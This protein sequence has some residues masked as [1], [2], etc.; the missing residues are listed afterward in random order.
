ACLGKSRHS[1]VSLIREEAPYSNLQGADKALNR[2]A[3]SEPSTT[4]EDVECTATTSNGTAA[5]VAGHIPQ[6]HASATYGSS[7]WKQTTVQ[8]SGK[9]AVSAPR[10]QHF[11]AAA[12]TAETKQPTAASDST[13]IWVQQFRAVEIPSASATAT[14]PQWRQTRKFADAYEQDSGR[15]GGGGGS[16]GG[17]RK[18]MDWFRRRGKDRG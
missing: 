14:R 3:E 6:L 2:P 1:Q 18:V 7:R 10:Q 17:A 9:T 16:S 15:H 11:R 5:K 13:S 12:A 4:D 8:V